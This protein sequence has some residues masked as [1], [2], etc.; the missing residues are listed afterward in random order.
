MKN[1]DNSIQA[2]IPK[3]GNGHQFVCYADCCSGIPGAINESNFASVNKIV[4]SLDPQPEFIC[5]P[6]DEI[7]G[8]VT[9]EKMLE[10][11]WRY[12]FEVEMKWLDK[13][14][15]PLFNTPGNHTVYDTMSEKVYQQV[16]KHLPQNGP[17]GQERLMY[18]VRRDDFLLAFLNSLNSELGGEGRV[19]TNWLEHILS[20][21]SDAKYKIV[22]GHHPVYSVNGFSGT[23]QRE[24]ATDNGK[25]FWNLLIK[26]NV[27]A[28]ICSHILAFDV[29]VH[30][31]VLQILT[32]GAGTTPHMPEDMEY[33]H[34]VQAAIDAN[35]LRYQVLDTSGKIR[36][37]LKWPIELPPSSTWSKYESGKSTVIFAGK[38][39]D[40]AT[41]DY[42]AIWRI[43][44]HSS[45]ELNGK[46][47]TLL[48]GGNNDDSLPQLW[49]GL[50]GTE[51]RI[52]VLLSPNPGRS[53]HLWLGPTLVPDR[54]FEIQLAIHTGMGPGGFLWRWNDSAPWSSLNSASPWGAERLTWP[55]NWH[56]GHD[57]YGENSAQFR[58]D[59]LEVGFYTKELRFSKD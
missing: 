50:R 27:M 42:L 18:Y 40:D 5:F 58:G 31:G 34:C 46:V 20:E 28:Y 52:S 15:I 33:L 37:W 45:A 56:I 3:D 26:H 44:G 1:S 41:T 13:D 48:C 14:K 16:M 29:Q 11:Q 6:G 38:K 23:N 7:R 55:V 53:P 59:N 4:A 54:T 21:H 35:G 39:K 57:Q 17:S 30:K 19:E 36:E 25:K 22:F 47:Q 2:L 43:S 8:L 9:C 32:A 51:Q 10:E 49:I 24:I 12:W